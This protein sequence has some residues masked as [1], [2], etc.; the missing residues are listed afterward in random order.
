VDEVQK[1]NNLNMKKRFLSWNEKFLSFG[2]LFA[3]FPR[4][5]T[6]SWVWS[7]RYFK[8]LQL[9]F[10]TR[11]TCPPQQVCCASSIRCHVLQGLTFVRWSVSLQTRQARENGRVT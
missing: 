1:P 8:C 7:S 3:L 2:T 10:K 11:S 4:N 6:D 5:F 9:G